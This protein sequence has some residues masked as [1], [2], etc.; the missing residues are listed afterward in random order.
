MLE[1]DIYMHEN[2][3]YMH[4]NENSMHEKKDFHGLEFHACKFHIFMHENEIF[5]H[6]TFMPRFLDAWNFSHV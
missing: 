2:D 3:I 4:E 1:N 6:K 5:I